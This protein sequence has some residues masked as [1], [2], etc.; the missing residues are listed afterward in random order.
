MQEPP[1]EAGLR[2]IEVAGLA[3]VATVS[4]LA[5]RAIPSIGFFVALVGAARLARAGPLRGRAGGT[6]P[7]S[8]PCSDRRDHRASRGPGCRSRRPD[9]AA[10]RVA[11]GPRGWVAWQMIV[12]AAIRL[13][14]NA[15][16]SAFVIVVLTGFEAYIEMYDSSRASSRWCPR[17][18]RAGGRDRRA[19]RLGRVRERGPGHGVPPWPAYLADRRGCYV[20]V[21]GGADAP[22]AGGSIRVPW[23]SRGGRVRPLLARASTGGLGAVAA[24]L[25]IASVACRGDRSVVPTG[26][27][28]RGSGR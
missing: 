26:A 7:A 25:A 20:H 2:E 1:G 19:P 15:P 22:T 21:A 12:C 4:F 10:A 3:H 13:V 14:Q 8:G 11:R 28:G 9:R 18:R 5:S 17:A 24:W 23:R 6:A 27:A 16:T